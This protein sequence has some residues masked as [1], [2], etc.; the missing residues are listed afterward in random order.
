MKKKGGGKKK[1]LHPQPGQ[2]FKQP[3]KS[4]HFP[5]WPPPSTPRLFFSVPSDMGLCYS[6]AQSLTMA[7]YFT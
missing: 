6:S 5:F 4:H 7:S 3:E 2:L 1:I